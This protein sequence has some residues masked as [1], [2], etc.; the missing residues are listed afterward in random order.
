MLSEI[1]NPAARVKGTYKLGESI[2]AAEKELKLHKIY[3]MNSNENPYG[4]SPL[5]C[6]AM[7]KAAETV[8]Y[9]PD[10]TGR[11]LR[12][13]LADSLGIK[14]ENIV[15][16][17]GASV[18]LTLL[19]E[20]FL[21]P[22]DEVI[23]HWPTYSGYQ[24]RMLDPRLAKAVRVPMGKDAKPDFDEMLAAITPRTRM[25]IVCNPNNPV[26]TVCDPDKLREFARKLP[27]DILLM[28]DEAYIDFADEGTCPS[29][30]DLI[31][32]LENLVVIRTFSK[33]SGLA[34][35]RIGY[36]TAC[37]EM[38]SYYN[39][40]VN[41][42]CASSMA[43]AGAEASLEDKAFREMTV[44][45]NRE[46]RSF[47]TEKLKEMGFYVYPS[48]ANFLACDFGIEP[49]KITELLRQKG[50]LIRGNLGVARITVGT[51]KDNEA[52]LEAI[53]RIREEGG[54]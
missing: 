3:K 11:S 13:K 24:R 17:E 32:E 5:A 6:E 53:R 33:I 30:I 22:G 39:N 31:G 35:A 23:Q 48:Q 45:K 44:R 47:L 10:P 20:M 50:I 14:P 25:V 9:Y 36:A 4:V 28:V 27:K 15:C 7:K 43:L 42:F 37:P 38:I 2:K 49:E 1:V 8:N 29:M 26:G 21:N 18:A 52:F 12:E 34:G 51:R 54:L 40:M 41:F 16:T 46:E 19:A